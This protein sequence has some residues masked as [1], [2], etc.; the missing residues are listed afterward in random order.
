MKSKTNIK[1]PVA[2][3]EAVVS[4]SPELEMADIP[5]VMVT[6]VGHELNKVLAEQM[7]ADCYITKPFTSEELKDTVKKHLSAAKAGPKK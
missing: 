4:P 5:V 7:G 1:K 3:L 2:E 6:G